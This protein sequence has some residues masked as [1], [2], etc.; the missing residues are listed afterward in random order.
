[1]I[2]DLAEGL[3]SLSR[4]RGVQLIQGRARF[5]D[6]HTVRLQD[7]DIRRI[8]FDHAIVAT[9]SLPIPFPGTAFTPGGPVMNSTGALALAAVPQ[10]L[11]V[12]GGG[13]VGL[14]LGSVYAAL[15]SRV[16]LVEAEERLLP[17]VDPDLVKPLYDRLESAFVAVHL[18]T[19][20]ASL[21]ASGDG[22]TAVLEGAAAGG[23]HA[24]ERALVAVGRR[25]VTGDLGLETTRVT[26]DEQ[27]FIRV[28]D[29]QRT[30]E[31]SIFAVGDV[32]G[33]LM[34]A[35]K[36]SREGKVAAEVIC[37]KP[38]AFDARAIPAIVYTDPQ[39]AW[40]GMS[41]EAARRENRPVKIQR[42]PWKYSGRA[43]TMGAPEGL[44]KIIVDPPS[45]RIIGAGMVGRDTEG[46]IAE[47][48]LAIEMGALAEDLALT[49]HP[50]PTL[51]ETEAEAAE[52]YM[53]GATHILP[54]TP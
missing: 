48:V 23:E 31:P 18:E 53:G 54:K 3:V 24:F 27:G 25:P 28:D 47:A 20:V 11:L 15:G 45:G 26:L 9:G 40:C 21:T 44:T 8:V 7:A 38:S 35:H 6:A 46:L 52:L 34:L 22:V 37:G 42:F 29:R 10:R 36:A 13:Y 51:S 43:A 33:G 50:H 49:I 1:V 17:E 4:R 16:T 14:E 30:A 39:I 5:E 2:R 32:T 19:R 12:V 41:E